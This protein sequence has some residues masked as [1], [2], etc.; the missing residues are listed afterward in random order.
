MEL[1]NAIYERRSI[2]NYTPCE[3]TEEEIKEL[4]KSA[5]MAPSWKNSETARFYV[6]HSAEARDAVRQ[7]LASFNKE[8]TEGA[9]AFIVTTVV[10]GDS[11]Y[12]RGEPTHLGN[13]FECFDNGLAVE[14]LLLKA[15]EM[16]Y[17][18]LIMGLYHE[19]ELREYF[20]VPETEALVVVIA[21]GKADASPDAPE[22]KAL[23][24]ILTIK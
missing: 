10:K 15:H 14:N 18:T 23:S 12:V 1:T 20:N 22:R 7:R 3:I 19:S 16:G 9:G 4:I 2:R 5:Q 24:E 13:G 8:R 11:G 17:G 21:V 6:A